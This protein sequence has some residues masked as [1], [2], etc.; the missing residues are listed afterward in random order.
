MSSLFRVGVKKSFCKTKGASKGIEK[1]IAKVL[2]TEKKH[3]S[4]QSYTHIHFR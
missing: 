2:V 4:P 1:I 3:D